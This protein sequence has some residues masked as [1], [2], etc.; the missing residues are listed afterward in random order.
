L[1]AEED[2]RRGS[3]ETAN[4]RRFIFFYCRFNRP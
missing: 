1:A 4:V 3:R 2:W